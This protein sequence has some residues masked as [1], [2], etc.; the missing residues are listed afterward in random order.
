MDYKFIDLFCGIG[1][2]RLAIVLASPA[3]LS[4][5]L[6]KWKEQQILRILGLE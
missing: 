3:S 2:F 4:V 6:A 5:Y 1:G